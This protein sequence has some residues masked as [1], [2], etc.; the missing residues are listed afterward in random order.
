MATEEKLRVTQ[1]LKTAVALFALIG[2]V[3]GVLYPVAVF[4]AGQVLFSKQAH[5][6]L[7]Y[8]KDGSVAGSELIGQSYMADRYFWGRPSA[9]EVNSYNAMASGG[10][11]YGPTNQKFASGVLNLT[12]DLK[13]A[14]GSESIP[15][16]LVMAS[17]SGLD[18]HISVES[19]LMQAERVAKARGVN[20]DAM[21]ALVMNH[22]EKPL[23]GILGKERVNVVMLNCDLDGP[24]I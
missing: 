16:D 22:V 21:K 17:A 15:S 20:L 11:N 13:S 3:T 12:E 1:V 7:F 6:S 8:A 23:F 10:S 9:T 19:A 18:P 14:Y 5:G 4:A 2:I 24:V